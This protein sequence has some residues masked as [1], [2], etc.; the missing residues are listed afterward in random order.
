[1]DLLTRLKIVVQRLAAR[2]GYKIERQ[3]SFA[4]YNLDLLDVILAPVARDPEF[5]FIQVGANDGRTADPIHHLVRRY[6]WRGILV[7][8]QPQVFA[9]LCMNYADQ[10]QLHFEN[11]ALGKSDGAM[12]LWTVP[13]STGLASLDR[14]ALRNRSNTKLQAIEIAAVSPSTLLNRYAVSRI[15]LLQVDTEGSDFEV[16]K[17][18]LET[19][20]RPRVIHYEYT[21]LSPSDRHSCIQ[22]LGRKGYRLAR[23]GPEGID[24]LAYHVAEEYSI[25]Q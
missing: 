22:L 16:I 23:S 5:F 10:P 14:L 12:T 8:P 15:D 4:P 25:S 2:Q 19:S 20:A 13:G 17:G 24:V 1:M 7:E 11:A 18:I 9:E 6:G 3:Q 21:H